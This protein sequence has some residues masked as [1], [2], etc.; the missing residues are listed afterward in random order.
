MNRSRISLGVVGAA[1]VL[2]LLQAGGAQ[3]ATRRMFSYDP[4]NE[5]TRNLAGGLTFEFDQ[6]LFS[7]HVLRIRATEGQATAELKSVDQ[8]RLGH[9]GLDGVV[10]GKPAERDL[11]E[12]LPKEEGGAMMAALCPG[13]QQVWL[14]VD[15]LRANRDMRVLVISRAKDAPARLCQTLDF[16]F[17][18]EWRL[19][20][21][22]GIDPRTVHQPTFPY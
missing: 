5:A 4:A 14:A 21:G 22:P 15:R 1:V 16:T 13:A 9:G 7:T 17:R 6:H 10:E 20:P 11:Y 8:A 18:G 12:I 2:L 3:A 19:P